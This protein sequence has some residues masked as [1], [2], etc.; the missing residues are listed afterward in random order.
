MAVEAPA[1]VPKANCGPGHGAGYG[2]SGGSISADVRH[3]AVPPG[4]HRGPP[5]LG[6]PWG[7]APPVW[8]HTGAHNIPDSAHDGW[9]RSCRLGVSGSGPGGIGAEVGQLRARVGVPGSCGVTWGAWGSCRNVGQDGALKDPA[10]PWR[11]RCRRSP[12][13]QDPAQHRR[14]HRS[15][16]GKRPTWSQTR[17]PPRRPRRRRQSTPLHS[18]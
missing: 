13:P 2:P 12:P 7:H 14:R 5:A 15:S 16:S 1:V 6:V 18:R 8:C 17:R 9:W 4:P 10:P 3:K 11:A